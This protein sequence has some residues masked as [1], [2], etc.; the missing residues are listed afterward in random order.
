MHG[1]SITAGLVAALAAPAA[2]FFRIPCPGRIVSERADPIVSP[3]AVSGHVHTIAGGNGFDFTMDYETARSSDCSSCPIKQDLSNYWTPKLYYQYQNGSFEDVAQSGDGNGVY[4]GM[5][6][7]YLQRPGPDND[8]LKAFPEGFRMLAGDPFKRN[9]TT[10]LAS[11]AVSFVCLD[12]TDGSSTSAGLPTKN[13]PDG[14]R[15]QIFFPSCWDGVNLDSADHKSHMSYPID[16]SY[17]SGRCPS[18]HPVHLISIF[19]EVNYNTGD[20]GSMWYGSGQPFVFAMGDP[21]GYGFHGDFVNGWDV[22]TL[23]TA[24]DTC[25]DDSGLLSDCDVFEFFSTEESQACIVPPKV[26]EAVTGI[27]DKLPGCNPVTTGPGEAPFSYADCPVATI[28]AFEQYFTD[29][30]SSLGWEYLGCGSDQGANRT[31]QLASESTGSMTVETCVKYCSG[32]GYTYA[33]LEY[34]SQCYCDNTLDWDRAP[35]TGVLGNC[36]SA[37]SGDNSEFCGGSD[38]LSIYKNCNGGTCTNAEYNGPSGAVAVSAVAA[39]VSSAASSSSSTSSISSVSS[40]TSASSS[41][42]TLATSKGSSTVALSSTATSSTTTLS[43]TKT[44]STATTSATTRSKH[45]K[46]SLTGSAS[47]TANSKHRKQKAANNRAVSGSHADARFAAAQAEHERAEQEAAAV[48]A[49]LAKS[50]TKKHINR[51]LHSHE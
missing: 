33:G 9:S 47:A 26:D 24:V 40:A 21:L 41:A 42:T 32:K 8:A 44:S 31:F 1:I 15:A 49:K 3:G 18:T 39:V 51:H 17:D 30:T 43:S 19:F 25:N 27:L 20:F 45:S 12:Y 4:G 13:C 23:Q 48:S 46:T 5:T 50:K 35:I 38:A 37:C 7:Y 2:A 16:G 6:V 11:Q 34:S 10:D 22:P 14:L 29:V 28:G 36:F